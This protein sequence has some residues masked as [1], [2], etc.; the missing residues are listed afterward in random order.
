MIARTK[1]LVLAGLILLVAA[2]TASAAWRDDY[3][4][5]RIG[6]V[7]GVD[8]TETRGRAEPFRAYLEDSLGVSVE[9]FVANDYP[10]LV[11]GQLTGRFQATFLSAAS[12][13]AASAA[14]NACVEPLVAAT[15][16]EG[17]E[18]FYA[19]LVVPTGSAIV[20]PAD[21]PGARLAVSA[22]DSIAGRLLPLALFAAD[23][24][25]VPAIQLVNSDGPAAAMAHLL[26]GE[27]DAALAWIG[28]SGDPALGY[29]RGVLHQLVADGTLAMD[30]ID[31]VW[32]SPLIPN[33]PL[34]VSADLPEDLKADLTAAMTEM[35]TAAPDALAAVGG[36][37]GFAAVTA[38]RYQPL[39]LLT[40]VE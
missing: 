11:S 40:E 9:L 17:D 30:A 12:F 1:R 20:G 29:D 8:A 15:S 33:G 13:A 6:M 18:G 34:T 16:S 7:A 2:Q 35:A 4:V 5:L 24:V 21:L 36:G 26:A 31:I 3:P 19:V 37:A 32:T 25:D 22:E 28:T 39:Q 10:A 38:E 27:A 23:G 14:C